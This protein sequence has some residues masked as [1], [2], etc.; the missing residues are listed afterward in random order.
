M[1]DW[2]VVSERRRDVRLG[3]SNPGSD[4]GGLLDV[5]RTSRAQGGTL[6]LVP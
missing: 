6:D 1:E 3:V 5:S 2:H 4:V